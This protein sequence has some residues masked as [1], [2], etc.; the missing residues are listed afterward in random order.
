MGRMED[1]RVS[2][3]ECHPSTET[4]EDMACPQAKLGPV[5]ALVSSAF[6]P[7]CMPDPDP[8]ITPKAFSHEAM[9]CNVPHRPCLF[10]SQR[11]FQITFYLELTFGYQVPEGKSGGR[12]SEVI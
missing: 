8:I 9:G 4:L 6:I 10:L 2:G 1:R 3:R 11:G 12:P 7:S 5:V